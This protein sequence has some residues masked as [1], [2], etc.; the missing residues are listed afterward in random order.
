MTPVTLHTARLSLRPLERT[1]AAALFEALSDPEV[2]AHWDWAGAASINEAQEFVDALLDDVAAGA[3]QYW[4]IMAGET[5]V[6]SCDLSE[7]DSYHKRGEIGF[8]LLRRH[9]GQGYA[10]EAMRAVVDYGVRR[11]GAE[12]L[13]ART[14]AGNA[15]SVALLTKLGFVHEGTLKGYVLRDGRRR[16]CELFGRVFV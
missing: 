2:M 11:L 14:H 10:S 4:A 9:W 16:D 7:I 15:A 12:R 5:F 6:G 13:S 1:D 3:A 8:M